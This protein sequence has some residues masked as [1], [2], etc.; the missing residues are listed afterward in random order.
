MM[1]RMTARHVD[2]R[3]LRTPVEIETH[4]GRHGNRCI[5]PCVLR[6]EA[7]LWSSAAAL[8]SR[9]DEECTVLSSRSLAVRDDAET[10][11]YDWN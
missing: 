1:H 3:G 8:G 11:H 6:H 10:T 5:G 9:Y 4:A 7:S 2:A